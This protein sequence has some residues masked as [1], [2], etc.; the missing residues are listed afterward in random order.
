MKMLDRKMTVAG[1]VLQN[2][3]CAQVFQRNRIDYCC[4]GG[5]PL[6]TACAEKG[7][8]ADAL[9]R[10]LERA[11]AER[12]PDAID[13][14]TL[15]TPA[16]VAH[17]V[18]KHHGYL[19]RAFPFLTALSAKVARVHG[20]HEPKLREVETLVADLV[21]A[22]LPHL[23]REEEILFPALLG[24]DRDIIGRELATMKEDHEQV[25]ALLQQLRSVACDF[26]P[27]DWACTS[28]RT[29]MAELLALETDVLRHVHL[30]NHVLLPRH[31]A[32]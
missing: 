16:L 20:D 11:I 24:G 18:T 21:A 26:T 3:A 9:V 28:Y 17:I 19:R 22:L 5:V 1:I 29:L 27:P 10:E 6:E 2:A 7:L 31:A 15:S 25:G 30:E 13:P 12:G 8:D 14:R 32:S 23:D 4:R